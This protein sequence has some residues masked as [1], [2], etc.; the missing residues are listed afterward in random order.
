MRL[1]HGEARGLA[2]PDVGVGAGAAQAPP[3]PPSLTAPCLAWPGG[4]R[5]RLAGASGVGWASATGG[6]ERHGM[7]AQQ[8][9]GG[10]GARRPDEKAVAGE[11]RR[12]GEG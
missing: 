10:A 6:S 5:A 2:I 4:Q 7:G 11:G 3:P 8:Q 9:R 1:Q 12:I